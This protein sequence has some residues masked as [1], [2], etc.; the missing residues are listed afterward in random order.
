MCRFVLPLQAL[1]QAVNF[2]SSQ[3]LMTIP[4]Y[5]PLL[6]IRLTTEKL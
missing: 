6:C 3:P 2:A 1:E 5:Q 4:H